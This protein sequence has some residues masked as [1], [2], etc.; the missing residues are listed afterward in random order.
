MNNY[1]ARYRGTNNV[2]VFGTSA[3][4]DEYVRE[5]KIVHPECEKVSERNV[6]PLL[7][8]RKPVFSKSFG[9]MAVLD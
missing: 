8:G 5:E 9:C 4:R 6:R 1:Y 7:R 3:E 2:L